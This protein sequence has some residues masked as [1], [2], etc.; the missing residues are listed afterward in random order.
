[1]SGTNAGL[2]RVIA[3]VAFAFLVDAEKARARRFVAVPRSATHDE[4]R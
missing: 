3:A 4:G 1:M 2:L